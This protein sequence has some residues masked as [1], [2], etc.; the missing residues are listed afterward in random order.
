MTPRTGGDAVKKEEDVGNKIVCSHQEH[1]S[2][3]DLVLL[4]ADRTKWNDE[5]RLLLLKAFRDVTS[6]DG[7]SYFDTI[8][9]LKDSN[10]P[11]V[12][13]VRYSMIL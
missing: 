9:R 11:F 2:Y 6:S 1:F 5:L 3:N 4:F 7:S 12:C 13:K 10:W 8:K